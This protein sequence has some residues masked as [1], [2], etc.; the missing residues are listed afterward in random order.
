MALHRVSVRK[1]PGIKFVK[2]LG[3]GKGKTFN[4]NDADLTRWGLLVT[5]DNSNLEALDSSK[6]IAQWRKIATAE[7]RVLLEPISAHGLW[8]KKTPFTY[9]VNEKADNNLI[10]LNQSSEIAAITRARIKWQQN[11]IFWRSVPPVTT[12]LHNTDGLISAIGIGEA[13]IGLQGTFS[14]W[15]DQSALRQFAY[16]DAP[17]QKVI[18]RTKELNWYAE[19]L[20]ARFKVLEKRGVL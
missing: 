12:S 17:H 7:F 10:N 9:E 19:E 11:F 1:Y 14:I 4:L 15:R 6:V 13:P 3:T 20:F 18:A 16:K 8:S 2:L 5:I